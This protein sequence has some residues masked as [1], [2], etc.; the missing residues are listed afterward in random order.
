MATLSKDEPWPQRRDN[1]VH[2]SMIDLANLGV[3]IVLL[4][5]SITFVR[6]YPPPRE[7]KEL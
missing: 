1:A 6:R 5:Y 4:V 3:R 2:P 7:F